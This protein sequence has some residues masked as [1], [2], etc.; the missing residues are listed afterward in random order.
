MNVVEVPIHR[1]T[2]SVIE[3][4]VRVL[5]VR[6]PNALTSHYFTLRAKPTRG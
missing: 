6:A 1:R 3:D 2:I 4:V 5:M